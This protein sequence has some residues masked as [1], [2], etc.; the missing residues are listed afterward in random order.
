MEEISCDW[1]GLIE[2][3]MKVC[4]KMGDLTPNGTDR[5]AKR[6]AIRNQAVATE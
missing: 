4:S 5:I 1:E 2:M 3:R 6:A